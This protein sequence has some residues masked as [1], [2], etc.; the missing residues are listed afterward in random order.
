MQEISSKKFLLCGHRSFAAR[1][2]LDLLT[3]EGHQV[4]CFSRGPIGCEG[5]M[6]TGSVIGMH[7]N[8]HFEKTY[9][10]VINY[11][12]LHQESIERNLAYIRSLLKF[13]EQHAVKHLIHI[14]SCSVYKNNAKF[15]DENAPIETDSKKKG[16]YAAVKAAQEAYITEHAP[17][18]LR[19]S[20]LRPGLILANGMGGYIGGIGIK[21]PWNSIIG[22]GN[23]RSQLPLI[24]RDAVNKTVAFL[25][26]NPPNENLETLL[27]AASPSPTRKQYLQVCCEIL[28]VGT[29]VRFFPVF[30]WLSAG[31]AAEI[32]SR[33]IGKGHFGILGKIR[34]VCRYQEFDASKT[35]EHVG[36]SF[37]ADWK[38]EMQK[39][40]DFQ[41]KNFD[42]PNVKSLE[43][44]RANTI[45]FIGYGRIVKQRHL[46]ALK[47]FEFKGSI[48]A[49][50]LCEYKDESGQLIQDIN[51]ANVQSSDLFVVATPGPV[52]LNAIEL[53]KEAQGPILVEK[54]LGYNINEFNRW[55]ELAKNRKDAIY[56]CHDCRY[57]NN[58]IAM[59]R[60]LKKYNPGRLL[61]VCVVFQSVPVNKDSASWLRAERKARTL[62]MDYGL[63]EIDLACMFGKGTPLL[64]DCR[65]ELNGQGETCLV[66]GE[67]AFDNY[68]IHFLFRQGINQRRT[69]LIYTFQNYSVTL[70]F[71][72]DIFVPHMADENFGISLLEAWASFKSTCS[73]VL[74]KLSGRESETSHAYAYQIAMSGKRDEPLYVENLRPVYELLFQISERVYGE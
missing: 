14:S 32:M 21:L 6:V 27:L 30:L 63:H 67:A 60:F 33:L 31:F 51:Q 54:P 58:V 3:S 69:K 44:T 28:G 7:S 40:F 22:L 25:V 37:S 53:L 10:T 19:V 35:E 41:A 61:N 8:P 59:I 26:N 62:L 48:E 55:S 71:A 46:S 16:P 17:K 66:E 42:L 24:T 9:D 68:S 74:D 29:K 15:V 13:C 50:D 34:S 57:K 2:L 38:T 43:K 36:I 70:G 1:G 64:K 72:P 39:T 11:I 5:S 20:H 23:A 56:V 49:Y 52:H 73:K 12:V 45:T 18:G 65:Y 4:D 47:T